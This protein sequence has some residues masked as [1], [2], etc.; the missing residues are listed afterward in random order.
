MKAYTLV[1]FMFPVMTLILSG[2]NIGIIWLGGHLIADM[3]M[4]VGNLV[5]FMT[6][7]TQI[8]M[9]FMMLSMVF[10]FVPRASASAARINEVLTRPSSVSDVPVEQQQQFDATQPASLTFK[11]VAFKYRGAEKMR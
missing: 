11:D 1:S 4:Q 5:A 10:V 6:Y 2:T 8:L 3:Q 7:A 9:S